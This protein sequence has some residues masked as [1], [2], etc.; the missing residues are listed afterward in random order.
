M[1]APPHIKDKALVLMADIFPT[2]FFGATNAFKLL[3]PEQISESTA[4]VIGCGPVGL[5]AVIAAMTFKPKHLFAVDSVD[6]RLELAKS[7]GAE[8]LNF[9]KDKEGMEKRIK[10]VTDG[11]GADVVIEV[12]GLSPALKTAFDL[13]RAWGIISSIGVHN[14]EVRIDEDLKSGIG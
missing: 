14:G 4:V 1:K 2:G 13:I 12:V 11:R 3:T 8:P 5:C 9:M 7:L 6:S 10:A